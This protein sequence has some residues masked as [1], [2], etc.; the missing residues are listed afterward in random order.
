MKSTATTP[1]EYLKS[2]PEDRRA[3]LTAVRHTILKN[4]DGD[5]E[6]CMQYGMIGYTVPHRVFPAGYHADPKKPLFFSG[7][8]SQKQY[9]V[10]HLTALYLDEKHDRWFRDAWAKT[11]KKLDMGKGC[12]RFKS[13]DDLPLEVVGQLFR[14]IPARAC[15]EIYSAA[16]KRK[17]AKSRAGSR[18]ARAPKQ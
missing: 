18:G 6:E 16:A 8:G 15:I 11:G 10:L 2:L 7:L 4:L 5:Y 14:R 17:P 3:A 1:T 9:M 12:V 13:L